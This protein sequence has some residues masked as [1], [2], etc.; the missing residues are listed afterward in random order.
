MPQAG[1]TRTPR[2]S[3][4]TRTVLPGGEV[5]NGSLGTDVGIAASRE[6]GI[7]RALRHEKCEGRRIAR[8][9]EGGDFVVAGD[10][11]EHGHHGR[12]ES[13][14]QQGPGDPTKRIPRRRAQRARGFF[15]RGT[16]RDEQRGGHNAQEC[17]LLPRER[18]CEARTEAVVNKGRHIRW[19]RNHA[20]RERHPREHSALAQRP[21]AERTGHHVRNG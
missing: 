21:Y 15:S 12:R 6:I 9:K 20:E 3:S 19:L 14:P 13:P 7:R 10:E 8:S 4:A 11:H 2:G 5:T 18:Q 16:A 17:H 1:K